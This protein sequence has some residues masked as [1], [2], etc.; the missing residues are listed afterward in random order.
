MVRV[1]DIGDEPPSPPALPGNDKTMNRFIDRLVA[2]HLA[3]GQT[4]A[5][6]IPGRFDAGDG[7]GLRTS[8]DEEE[9]SVPVRKP[10]SEVGDVPEHE[11]VVEVGDVAG[12]GDVAENR[13]VPEV[14]DVQKDRDSPKK[15]KLQGPGG[16]PGTI[17]G[18]S[19]VP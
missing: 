18:G 11:D 17:L 7:L 19:V 14:G 9:M 5:P 12:Y 6:R 16:K 2:R 10:G 3:P 1:G 13:D 8:V 4:I 15:M